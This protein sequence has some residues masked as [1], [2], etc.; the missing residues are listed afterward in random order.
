MIFCRPIGPP[1]TVS[2]H[3]LPSDTCSPPTTHHRHPPLGLHPPTPSTLHSHLSPPNGANSP[4]LDSHPAP[5]SSLLQVRSPPRGTSNLSKLPYP[6]FSPPTLSSTSRCFQ[7]DA[8]LTPFYMTALGH[9]SSER[10]FTC[11]N[12]DTMGSAQGH[13]PLFHPF[14]GRSGHPTGQRILLPPNPR[15]LFLPLGLCI[16]PQL[17][18][19]S[20]A[21]RRVQPGFQSLPG[22]C[23]HTHPGVCDL[24]L[25][26]DVLRHVILRHRIHHKV[27]IAGGALSW[28]VLV[29]PCTLR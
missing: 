22:T 15:C 2:L 23:P 8:P 10:C 12:G 7:E 18:K 21:A 17:G 3:Q 4:P 26:Q 19:L 27:L 9:V 13:G 5:P 20:P 29:T 6:V 14:G 25:P 24:E 16:S 1:A 11:S 28:P